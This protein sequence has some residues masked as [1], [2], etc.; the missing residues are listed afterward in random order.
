MITLA[1]AE[2]LVRKIAESLGQPTLE[3]QAPK[4]AQDFAELGRAASRRLEQCASMIEAGEELQALQLAETPPP[5]LDLLTLLSF[6]QASE[7][8]TYCQGRGLPWAEPFFD[9]HVRLLNE[10]YGKGTARAQPTIDRL[11]KAYREASLKAEDERGLSILRVI[12]RM[13][14]AEQN[15]A[16]EI[17]R[18]EEKTVRARL[19]KLGRILASGDKGAV[20]TQ[21]R[22]VET[23]G[24]PIPGNHPAWQ[25]A[26]L[27]RCQQLLAQAE[28]LRRSDSWQEA[29]PIVQEIKSLASQH[30]VLFPEADVT[31][32]E[33]LEQ[34]TSGERQSFAQNQDFQ[35]AVE[36]LDY[37]VRASESK[38]SDRSQGSVAALQD[39]LS[40]LTAKWQEAERFGTLDEELVRRCQ[41]SCDWLQ[42]QIRRGVKRKRTTAV[43]V[44]LGVAALLALGGFVFWDFTTAG[45]FAAQLDRLE[46]ARRVTDATTLLNEIPERLKMKPRLAAALT[47]S[48]EFI[49]RE[50]A[51]KKDFEEK[52]A[53]LQ[54]MAQ[55]GF[56]ND[57]AAVES[58]Q[59]ACAQALDRI[60]LE[61]QTL[62]QANLRAF[63]Q[64][65]Q[66]RLRAG[67][68]AHNAEFS[69]QLAAAQQ[70][71][72]QRLNVTNSLEMLRQTLPEAQTTLG[73]LAALR[74]SPIRLDDNLDRQYRHLTNE[75]GGWSNTIAQWTDLHARLPQSPS[76]ERYLDSVALISKSLLASAKERACAAA[77]QNQSVDE[78]SLL[79]GLLLPGQPQAWAALTNSAI[80]P[81]FRPA[82]PTAQEKDACLRLRDDRNVQDVYW[83]WLT[84]TASNPNNRGKSK[85]V[86]VQGD[87]STDR[88][89]IKSGNIYDPEGSRDAL[90]FDLQKLASYEWDYNRIEKR[91]MTRECDAFRRLGLGDL[92]DPNTGKYQKSVLELMDRVSQDEG[93]SATF[94]AFVT[95]R[96]AELAEMRPAEWG[97]P[98]CPSAALHIQDLKRLGAENVQSGDWMVPFRVASYEQSFKDYFTRIHGLSLEK[99]AQFFHR[100][101]SRACEAKFAFAGYIGP[102]GQLTLTQTN[103]DWSELWGWTAASKTPGLILARSGA[104]WRTV[105]PPMCYTPLFAFL[106]APRKIFEQ[107][108]Q[109]VP[110]TVRPETP[111]PPLFGGLR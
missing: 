65:W 8:R 25:Q 60:A 42:A 95:L 72:V 37:Q 56:T 92:I 64:Q 3:A 24:L 62:G 12:H 101:T 84:N 102:D 86:L 39:E 98:W 14:P 21:L 7:W 18:L 11:L 22:E 43:A 74:Q 46:T 77:W 31:R 79:G 61:Y 48:G 36:A 108:T 90:R 106:G 100:L 54:T 44:G 40:S 68:P 83:Y 30:S 17:K 29:E 78:G 99:E 67:E 16:Q 82:E 110:F 4:L 107:A 5:L 111:L 15:F 1:Q 19:D 41:R 10:T 96:L 57:L 73:K 52:L 47:R 13:N 66:S 51:L 35:R 26:Q 23:S 87:L 9:K 75:V 91:G 80:A 20:L 6:R 97:L 59:K 104:E 105:E 94:R 88:A 45:Q 93:A 71:V 81:P 89:G 58:E 109:N 38:R 76:L 70:L 63:Q 103:A 53:A 85:L 2:R 55:R 34:W 69:N 28:A 27:L 50:L 49:S 32:F 33:R